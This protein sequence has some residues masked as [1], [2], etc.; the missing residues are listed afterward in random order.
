MAFGTLKKR[1]YKKNKKQKKKNKNKADKY[2]RSK[3][4]S[5]ANHRCKWT[6]HSCD[7]ITWR[8]PSNIRVN[9]FKGNRKKIIYIENESPHNKI[10]LGKGSETF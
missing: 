6:Y 1:T 5:N 2:L 8:P 9:K 10:E 4:R 3:E 7:H